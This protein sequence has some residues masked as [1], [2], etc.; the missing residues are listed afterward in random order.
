MGTQVR[1]VKC[2]AF[3]VDTT[4][5]FQGDH[6]LSMRTELEAVL[7]AVKDPI[8]MVHIETFFF[9]KK[10]CQGADENLILRG[11]V[12][13][14]LREANIPYTLHGPTQ[15]KKFIVGHV[16]PTKAEIEKHGKTKAP[17][18]IVVDALK[19]KFDIVMS[20]STALAQR[21]K[22]KRV[23]FK[24]DVSD[25]IGIGLYGIMSDT[26]QCTILPYRPPDQIVVQL[27]I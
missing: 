23:Q 9:S 27:G 14:R 21:G 25:A 12:Y 16:R 3:L 2:G 10:F 19:S 24:F 17:K 1:V 6:M 26:P 18:S 8:E 22:S 4:S 20:S 13:Q 11:A 5:S 15:W 7:D